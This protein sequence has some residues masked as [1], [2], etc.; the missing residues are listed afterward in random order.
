MYSFYVIIQLPV[1]KL[2]NLLM[3]NW[4]N[5]SRDA[6]SGIRSTKRNVVVK[7]AA[8]SWLNLLQFIYCFQTDVDSVSVLIS[9]TRSRQSLVFK[10]GV[11]FKPKKEIFTAF[12]KPMKTVFWWETF[13]KCYFLCLSLVFY[14]Y[15]NCQ[16]DCR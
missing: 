9:T 8:E 16:S 3:K 5:H 4:D 11:K 14:Y 10:S 6:V 15:F 1:E 12:I 2:L 13:F 7:P